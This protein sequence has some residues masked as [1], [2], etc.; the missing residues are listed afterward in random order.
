MSRQDPSETP[1]FHP[2]FLHARREAIVIFL[3]W[4]VALVWS[5]GVCHALGYGKTTD[6]LDTVWGVPAWIFWGIALP[7]VVADVFALWFC[8]RY[9][10]DDDLSGGD[11]AAGEPGD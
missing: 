9:M 4:C 2:T 6:P 10:V 7:W 3:A 5:V 8:F 1:R 11:G